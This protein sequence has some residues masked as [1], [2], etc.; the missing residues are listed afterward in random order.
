[1]GDLFS[2]TLENKRGYSVSC[3]YFPIDANASVE[4]RTL[5]IFSRLIL[6]L[7]LPYSALFGFRNPHNVSIP[8]RRSLVDDLNSSVSDSPGAT[9]C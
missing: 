7:L 1:M 5:V 6:A 2:T 3:H 9:S 4:H 8:P